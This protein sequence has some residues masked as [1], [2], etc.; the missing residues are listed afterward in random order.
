[1]ENIENKSCFDRLDSWW[2]EV[3]YSLAPKFAI[4]LSVIAGIGG[5][6]SGTYPIWAGVFYGIANIGV[7]FAGI[8]LTLFAKETKQ[9]KTNLE[10]LQTENDNLKLTQL[11]ALNP[12]TLSTEPADDIVINTDPF[13]TI[14]H[15]SPH[16]D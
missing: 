14:Y 1:M 4:T 7:F 10:T 8:S 9:H 6:L 16:D 3:K 2:G 12:Y 13:D 5:I 15:G 11:R